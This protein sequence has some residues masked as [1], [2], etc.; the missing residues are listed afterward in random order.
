MEAESSLG[1][2][3]VSKVRRG[4]GL[5]RLLLGAALIVLGFGL[6]IMVWAILIPTL[7]ATLPPA[8]TP[9][10]S[11]EGRWK[12]AKRAL[13]W[14]GWI[15]DSG[16]VVGWFGDESWVEGLVE[17]MEDGS[18]YGCDGGHREA[19]LEMITNRTMPPEAD[20]GQFWSAWWEGHQHLS[21]EEWIREGFESVGISLRDPPGSES[22]NAM[23]LLTVLGKVNESFEGSGRP[24]P[25]SYLGDF[26]FPE[27]LRYNAYRWLRDSGFDPVDWLLEE[28]RAL[29]HNQERGLREFRRVEEE[30]GAVI[31]GRLEFAPADSWG[32]DMPM[33]KI[34]ETG[35]QVVLSL[36]V[37]LAMGAGVCLV[38]SGWR[39]LA[40]TDRRGKGRVS[41]PERVR[42]DS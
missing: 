7:R 38:A 24:E 33:P 21:Q 2:A 22:E 27:A 10:L 8:M 14:G 39:R 40:A 1:R 4:R 17:S 36:A 15:H 13:R 19:A 28:G 34:L 35:P 16:F 18:G 6:A 9:S 26:D 3:S 42:G 23:Q 32:A 29:D 31:P 11:P 41:G 20:P 30:F 5:G 25:E 37:A 12:D